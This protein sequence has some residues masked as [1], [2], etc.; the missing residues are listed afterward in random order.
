MWSGSSCVRN[1]KEGGKEE[2][3]QIYRRKKLPKTE[4]GSNSNALEKAEGVYYWLR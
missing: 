3:L 1:K 2:K 4:E